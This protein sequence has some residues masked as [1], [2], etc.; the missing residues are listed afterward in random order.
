MYTLAPPP[1]GDEE[2]DARMRERVRRRLKRT[3]GVREGAEGPKEEEEDDEED[4][5]DMET[6]KRRRRLALSGPDCY[7]FG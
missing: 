1:Q 7:V 2:Y 4:W 6:R 3:A 5:S